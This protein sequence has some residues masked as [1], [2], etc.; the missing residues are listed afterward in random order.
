MRAKMHRTFRSLSNEPEVRGYVR[1]PPNKCVRHHGTITSAP[2]RRE[3]VA[4]PHHSIIQ[5]TDR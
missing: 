3:V 4:L 5:R 2:S 1:Y